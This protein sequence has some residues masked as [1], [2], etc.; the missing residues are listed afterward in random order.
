MAFLADVNVV[1]ALLHARH[2]AS[3]RAIAWLE[4]QTSG[5]GSSKLSGIVSFP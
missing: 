2:A 4:R 3:K 5:M 1:I